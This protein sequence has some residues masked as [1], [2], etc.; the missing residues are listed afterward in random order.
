MDCCLSGAIPIYYGKLDIIDQKI[1]NLKRILFYIPSNKES[2][3]KIIQ[4]IK[5]VMNNQNELVDFYNQDIFLENA[6]VQFELL[7]EQF[8]N[9]IDNI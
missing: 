1:F 8:R 5:N 4:K 9:K 3:E 7:I 2:I 6:H